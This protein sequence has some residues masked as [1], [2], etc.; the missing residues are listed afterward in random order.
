MDIKIKINKY[1]ES[2]NNLNNNEL[3]LYITGKDVNYTIVNTIR[4][5]VMSSVPIYAFH[6]DDMK[7]DVNTTIYNRSMIPLSLSLLIYYL[8]PINMLTGINNYF[9]KK[10]SF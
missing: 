5:L 8:N 7:F 3:S 1:E 9:L 6:Q 4:R 10:Y 2:V